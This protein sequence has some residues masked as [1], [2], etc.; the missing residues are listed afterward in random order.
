MASA[1]VNAGI[2]IHRMKSMMFCPR[3]LVGRRV[4]GFKSEGSGNRRD[5]KTRA[6]KMYHDF[7]CAFVPAPDRDML[8]GQG[9]DRSFHRNLAIIIRSYPHKIA[10]FAAVEVAVVS[11]G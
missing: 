9:H 2:E 1:A 11:R 3:V 4:R 8:G 10:G 7:P 5:Q 6:G